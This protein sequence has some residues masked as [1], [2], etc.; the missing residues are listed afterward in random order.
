MCVKLLYVCMY[1]SFI[2]DHFCGAKGPGYII[3]RD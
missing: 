1:V 3:N 2:K